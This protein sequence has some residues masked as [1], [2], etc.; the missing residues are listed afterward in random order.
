MTE[1]TKAEREQISEILERRSNE[2]AGFSDEYRRKPEHYGSVQL[3]LT[4]EIDRLRR[5]AERV[6]PAGPEE[7]NT[8]GN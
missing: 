5:L 7:E 3:A 6:S 1:L 4:R 2:I 8:D